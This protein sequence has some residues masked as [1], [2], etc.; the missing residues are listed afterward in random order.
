MRMVYGTGAAGGQRPGVRLLTRACMHARGRAEGV[1]DDGAQM[2]TGM[3]PRTMTK[4]TS[5][6]NSARSPT[7]VLSHSPGGSL[8]SQRSGISS[9][10]PSGNFSTAPAPS[11]G[12]RCAASQ[13]RWAGVS[14]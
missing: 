6:P 11:T 4:R 2:Y 13:G 3:D 5:R 10:Q 9:R 7:S 8:R 1:R 14:A 12:G